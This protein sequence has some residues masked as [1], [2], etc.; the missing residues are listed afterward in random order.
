MTGFKQNGNQNKAGEFPKF[1]QE[2]GYQKIYL[3]PREKDIRRK[4][5]GRRIYAGKDLHIQKEDCEKIGIHRRRK[6]GKLD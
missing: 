3:R 5:G 4:M 6:R 2:K 1:N